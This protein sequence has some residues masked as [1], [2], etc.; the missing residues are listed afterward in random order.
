MQIN[1]SVFLWVKRLEFKVKMGNVLKAAVPGRRHIVHDVLHRV[2]V[3]CFLDPETGFQALRT[4]LFSS[5]CYQ[6]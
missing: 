1:A 6:Y 2:L 4:L 5:C 3:V